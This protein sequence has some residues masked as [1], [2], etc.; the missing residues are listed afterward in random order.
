MEPLVVGNQVLVA[1]PRPDA[2]LSVEIFL[3]AALLEYLEGLKLLG[4]LLSH[5]LHLTEPTTAVL[6]V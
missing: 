5:Q 1:D 4:L 3:Q 6:R 2:Q